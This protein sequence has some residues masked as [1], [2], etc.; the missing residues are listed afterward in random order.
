MR[1]ELKVAYPIE[2]RS[3]NNGL[4]VRGSRVGEAPTL[5]YNEK[6]KRR[7][8]QW[9][10]LPFITG[11]GFGGSSLPQNPGVGQK[12]C[13]D[14]NILGSGQNRLNWRNDHN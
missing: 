6:G 1:N 9:G 8:R 5:H 10:S 12:A 14:R 2:H 11:S 13:P 7:L 4:Y 3:E